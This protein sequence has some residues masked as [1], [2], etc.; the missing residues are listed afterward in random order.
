[1]KSKKYHRILNL[2]AI[3]LGILSIIG[4]LLPETIIPTAIVYSGV[5]VFYAYCFTMMLQLLT[6]IVTFVFNITRLREYVGYYIGAI[7][8][9][10]V[11]VGVWFSAMISLFRGL[12]G[13]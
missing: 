5:A 6:M 8:S 4:F 2:V 13:F 3:I 1:M 9:I 12:E 10:V 11:G 7:M